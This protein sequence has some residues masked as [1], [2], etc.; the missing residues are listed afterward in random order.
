MASKPEI[1]GRFEQHPLVTALQL[2][3]LTSASAE[4]L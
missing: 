3:V 4:G 2:V 1:S